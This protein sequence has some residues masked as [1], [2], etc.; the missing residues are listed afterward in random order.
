[1][2]QFHPQQGRE[3]SGMRP[4]LVLSPIQYNEKVGLMIACPITSKQKGY[5]FE[6]PLPSDVRTHG[7]ILADHVKN[8]DWKA[9]KARFIEHV[10]P[11]VVQLALTKLHLLLEF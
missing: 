8:L 5:P 2:L 1:M 10:S 7:V 11:A 6:V 9:R 4:A 3:Q